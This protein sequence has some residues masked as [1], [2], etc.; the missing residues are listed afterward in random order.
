MILAELG[1]VAHVYSPSAQEVEAES[2]GNLKP[3]WA[4]YWDPVSKKNGKFNC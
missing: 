3:D 1:V 4:T 2:A